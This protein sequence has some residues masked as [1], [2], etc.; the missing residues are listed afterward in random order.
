MLRKIEVQYTSTFYNV[1]DN[2]IN[3]LAPYSSE[4]SVINRLERLIDKFEKRVKS[5][6]F[7]CQISLQ[8][9]EVGV[10][11]FREYN[12]DKF[13]ILYRIIETE[14]ETLIFVDALNF[15]KTGYSKTS[16]RLLYNLSLTSSST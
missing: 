5:E 15:T 2:L 9:V 16:S 7:S 6:P 4:S 3:H 13:R 11:I 10:N 12:T 8:L 1:M 14:Q